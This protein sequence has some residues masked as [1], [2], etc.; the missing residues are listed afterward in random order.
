MDFDIKTFNALVRNHYQNFIPKRELDDPTTF[1]GLVEALDEETT[2]SFIAASSSKKTPSLPLDVWVLILKDLNNYSIAALLSSHVYVYRMSPKIIERIALLRHGRE[3]WTEFKRLHFEIEFDNPLHVVPAL[4]AFEAADS[5]TTNENVRLHF[6]VK[7]KIEIY[8]N[9]GRDAFFVYFM[10]DKFQ[11]TVWF[12]ADSIFLSQLNHS[13]NEY[14]EI[15][16]HRFTPQ[17]P[18]K[19]EQFIFSLL[20]VAKMKLTRVE[21]AN[22]NNWGNDVPVDTSRITACVAC[23]NKDAKHE[24]MQHP[25]RTFCNASCQKTFYKCY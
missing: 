15:Q 10:E 23:G 4:I 8:N 20:T 5:F 16:F 3:S 11:E 6:G 21:S 1:D 9:G 18:H 2:L 17:D 24:E 12:L 13:N 22:R 14:M 25:F 19:L 7:D